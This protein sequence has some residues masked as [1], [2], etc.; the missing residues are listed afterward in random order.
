[1]EEEG[2]AAGCS[3]GVWGGG[4]THERVR[5]VRRWRWWNDEER[6]GGERGRG[7]GK[8]TKQWKTEM[9]EGDNKKKERGQGE[10]DGWLGVGS[11]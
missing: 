9:K 10:K 3:R 6:K 7:E 11:K 4:K 2:T 5:G 8:R 1:M